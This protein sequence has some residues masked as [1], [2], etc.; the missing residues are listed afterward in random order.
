MSVNN[1]ISLIDLFSGAGGLGL[2]AKWAGGNLRLSV[3]NDPVSCETLNANR[4]S[5]AGLVLQ[6][7]VASV[8]GAQIRKAAGLSK[9]EPVI[10]IGGPPCQPFSKAAY[11]TDSGEDSRYRRARARGK[12]YP[13]P[14]GP[15]KPR[16]D[17]R[18]SLVEE[19]LRLVVELRAQGFLFEN[20]PSLLH[21]RNRG[22][23]DALLRSFHDNG[24]KTRLVK[25]MATEYGVPQMRERI[26]VLG[27]RSAVPDEPHP[28][29]SSTA[30]NGFAKIITAGEAL[31]GLSTRKF[32]EPEEVVTG[33]W[34]RHLRSIPPG[35]NY[36]YHTKWAGHRKPSFEAETRFW[37]FLL[38][39]SPEKPSWTISANPGPWT[40]PFHWDGRRLRT[41]ELA[42]LQTFPKDYQ[43]M[44]NRRDRVRQIGNAVPPLLAMHMCRPLVKAFSNK[45]SK[46]NRRENVAV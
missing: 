42:A 32:F 11:W 40:G 37:N 1:N 18:R 33:R 26:F 36:K 41:A 21:P 31:R 3:D 16:P 29:H 8:S 44:G 30:S 9:T 20:V 43:F 10:V 19:Y 14:S 46:Q 24:Y 23:M 4:L 28:T 34:A 27:L 5:H 38:K 6:A 15:T 13:R 25:A 39:L 17:K 7:D 45:L 35:W 22:T 12:H 2:G